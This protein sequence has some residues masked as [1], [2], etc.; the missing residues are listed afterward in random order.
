MK[1]RVLCL[2]AILAVAAVQ[3]HAETMVED[4]DGNGAYSMDEM[5]AA[6]PELT[7][8]DFVEIDTDASGDISTEEL[9]LATESGLL[10][11]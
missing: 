9:T 2:A 7:E 11:N 4:T 8:D 10:S 3:T 5:T 6:Y 1:T